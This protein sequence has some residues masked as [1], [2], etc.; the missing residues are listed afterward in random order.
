MHAEPADPIQR[1]FD[2]SYRRLV[3]QLYGVCG[4][5]GDRQVGEVV[6]REGLALVVGQGAERGDDGHPVL[7]EVRLAALA[8]S[9]CLAEQPLAEGSSAMPRPDDVDRDRAQPGLRVVE[10]FEGTAPAHRPGE[11]LLHGVLGEVDV[12]EDADQRGY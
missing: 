11:R 9:S 5:L 8:R 1:C 3:G 10:A 6:Q 2:A 4:D 12:T 7:A